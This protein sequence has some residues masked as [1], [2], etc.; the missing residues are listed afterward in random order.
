MSNT[1]DQTKKIIVEIDG[2][3]GSITLNDP[4]NSNALGRQMVRDFAK[5][6]TQLDLDPN[7]RAVIIKGNG[8]NFCAGANLKEAGELEENTRTSD[9]LLAEY[10][11]GIDGIGKSD[12]IYIAAIQGA[13]SGISGA[14]VMNCD[15]AIMA[16]G[17]YMHQPFM[18][19]SLVP[20]GGTHWHLLRNLGYKKSLNMILNCEKL[21]AEECVEAGLVNK[22]VPQNELYEQAHQLA[23]KI[24]QGPPLA[25]TASKRILRAAATQ[26]FEES[27]MQESYEQN[28][29][30]SSADCF[31]GIT[32]F[33]EKRP[34]RFT[35]S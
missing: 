1:P 21:A 14:I 11:P 27:F 6:V 35:G 19:I 33:F 7:I 18:T 10:F 22:V 17:A 20:D 12:K 26:S 34:P 32:A 29:L 23:T 30:A 13:A 4:E 28:N 8:K 15:L 31:E 3:I 25:Q 5:A 2:P 9:T 16:E 24:V